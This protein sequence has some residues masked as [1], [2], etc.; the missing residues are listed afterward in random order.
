MQCLSVARHEPTI[1]SYLTFK[2]LPWASISILTRLI[3]NMIRFMFELVLKD[4]L[5][6]NMTPPK[7]CPRKEA[8]LCSNEEH[9]P[10]LDIAHV[11]STR[12]HLC[13]NHIVLHLVRCDVLTS[14]RCRDDNQQKLMKITNINKRESMASTRVCTG[15][16]LMTAP[17]C[18]TLHGD[19]V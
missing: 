7:R 18:T 6:C 1:L 3:S 10:I 15:C 14:E 17:T 4:Y 2:E 16:P 12:W 9:T 19:L 11:G 13:M 8:W 5:T